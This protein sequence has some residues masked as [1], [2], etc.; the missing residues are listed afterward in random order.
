M[1][2][3]ARVAFFIA[4]QRFVV[5]EFRYA[6]WRRRDVP[7]IIRKPSK[8][9]GFPAILPLFYGVQTIFA[10][11]KRPP[12]ATNRAYLNLTTIIWAREEK[13]HVPSRVR[14]LVCPRNR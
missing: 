12:H 2:P 4:R 9:A 13:T 10:S 6:R 7:Q 3:L 11:I 14:R 5:V 8:M 1:H